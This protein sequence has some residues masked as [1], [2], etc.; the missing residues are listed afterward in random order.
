MNPSCLSSGAARQ[1]S[2]LSDVDLDDDDVNTENLD[3]SDYE[4][5]RICKQLSFLNTLGGKIMAG[6]ITVGK[7]MAG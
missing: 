5:V 6:I 4:E 2:C 1:D 3:Y 7:N